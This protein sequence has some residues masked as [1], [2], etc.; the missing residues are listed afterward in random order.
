LTDCCIKK[1][2]RYLSKGEKANRR[3]YCLGEG[4]KRGHKRLKIKNKNVPKCC[5]TTET[6]ISIERVISNL[7]AAGFTGCAE[8][9]NLVAADFSLRIENA[10]L[11]PFCAT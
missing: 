9:Q 6:I 8:S 10:I 1:G 11:N 5:D 2:Q 7:V 3:D 4:G